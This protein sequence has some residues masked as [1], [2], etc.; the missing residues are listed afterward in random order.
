MVQ[1]GKRK[2]ET[3]SQEDHLEKVIA[4]IVE[5]FNDCTN[6]EI[7][8]VLANVMFSIGASLEQCTEKPLLSEEILTRWAEK[9][10]L[11]NALMAQA[12][13]M[14]ECWVNSAEKK[15]IEN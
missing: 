10:T 15:G 3:K 12:K 9:P 8:Q 1:Q 7:V 5:K 11:G 14:I 4:E 2:E 13:H 6:S